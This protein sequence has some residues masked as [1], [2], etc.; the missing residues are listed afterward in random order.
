M[1]QFL[2]ESQ[3]DPTLS[4]DA[5]E[6]IEVAIQCLETAFNINPVDGSLPSK[7]PLLEIFTSYLQ[8]EG[9]PDVKATISEEDKAR[10]DALKNEGNELMKKS[11]IKEA[12]E[13]Y[14]KA[15]EIDGTNPIYYCNRAAAYSKLDDHLAALEDCKVAIKYDPNYSKAY[16][17]MG[18][19]FVHL[20][21]P[22]RARDSYKKA[23]EL[24]P[25]PSNL[26]NLSLAEEKLKEYENQFPAPGFNLG[27]LFSNP[28]LVNSLSQMMTDPNMQNMMSNF[29]S[30]A[31]TAPQVDQADSGDQPIQG[32]PAGME[33]ILQAGQHFASQ[34]QAQNP[35]LIEQLKSAFQSM[36]KD[37]EP[38]KKDEGEN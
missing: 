21:D 11:L 27:N 12:L 16:C 17:R 24:D 32:P 19:A 13:S 34:M 5:K 23:A 29:M 2:T 10:A 38:E 4:S 8:N 36:P 7:K 30:S 18:L 22:Q 35:E 9:E 31:M 6:S 14:T 33:A 26:S 25:S 1:M 15:I 20:K 3:Q 37:K 28:N